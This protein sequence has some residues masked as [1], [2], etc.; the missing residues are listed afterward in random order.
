MRISKPPPGQEVGW[1]GGERERFE[2]GSNNTTATARERGREGE[3]D[4]ETE[5]SANQKRKRE[6]GQDGR[7]AQ[8]SGDGRST[9]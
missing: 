4:R 3:R 2:D 7:A 9:N 8:F 5:R 6:I 1:I